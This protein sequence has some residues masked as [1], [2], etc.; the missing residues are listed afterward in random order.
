MIF[1]FSGFLCT[2]VSL[3]ESPIIEYDMNLNDPFVITVSRELGSGGHT[4]AR[5]LAEKLN[6]RF[7][8]K[9]LIK[10]L[11]EKFNL[12][13]SAI[14]KL[15]GEKKNWLTDFI[16]FI[17]P[18]PSA[19]TLD[20]DPKF[21]LEFRIDV[22]NTDIYKAEAE[23]LQG[24]AQE[25]SCV[26]TGRSGFYVFK[27]HPNH[28]H[29]FI[30]ASYPNRVQRVMKKQGLKEESAVELINYI[31]QARENYIQ[32]HTGTSRYDARNYDLVINAD[33]HTEEQIAD[34]IISYIK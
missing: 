20:V 30:T 6:C 23:I 11:K 19:K 1:Y 13:T 24:L 16:Q 17:T 28:L 32:R 15:K 31:D 34:L 9:D 8:D 18:M 25:G 21:D 7:C 29:V 10:A 14:E 3:G 2:F 12:T 5:L 26:I 22:T 33:G 4:V 27:D